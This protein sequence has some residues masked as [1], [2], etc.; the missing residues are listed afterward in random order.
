MITLPFKQMCRKLK[1]ESFKRSVFGKS[2]GVTQ[3]MNPTSFN[4][5]MIF[6]V[7]VLL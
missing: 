1:D 7:T 4:R 5:E 6:L 3:S 2:D